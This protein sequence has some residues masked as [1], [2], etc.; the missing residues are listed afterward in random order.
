MTMD[1]AVLPK[2]L[3]ALIT[4][5]GTPR[6][7]SPSR[8]GNT[9]PPPP[10]T[11]GITNVDFSNALYVFPLAPANYASSTGISLVG[12]IYLDNTGNNANGMWRFTVDSVTAAASCKMFF[13]DPNG[14]G[15][16]AWQVNGVVFLGAD[17]EILGD[18]NSAMGAI[19]LG[20]NAKIAGNLKTD[21]GAINL[22]AAAQTGH[23][24]SGAAITLGANA[25]CKNMKSVGAISL[26]AG[27]NVN[28]QID[29]DAAITVGAG[30]IVKGQVK[31]GAAITVGAGSSTC[32]LCG[33]AAV[34]LGAGTTM[35]ALADCNLPGGPGA[36]QFCSQGSPA[37]CA[38][39]LPDRC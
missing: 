13:K 31:A 38:I 6:E 15:T 32:A 24:D 26:G 17:A 25:R 2:D 9:A 29:A 37:V 27:A 19:N 36:M 20:A 21:K 33:G 35:N 12:D 3:A 14:G 5:R 8:G 23:L 10:V 34:T 11:I 22:G 39:K 18:M 7:T 4:T 16:V 1:Y 30:S 28:G